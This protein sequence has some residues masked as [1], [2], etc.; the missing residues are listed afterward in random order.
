MDVAVRRHLQRDALVQVIAGHPIEVGARHLE[1]GNPRIGC[2]GNGF[3][4]AFVGLG[5]EGDVE[6]G[7]RHSGAQALEHRVA[8]E[9]GFG[10]VGALGRGARSGLRAFGGGVVGSHVS[11]RCGTAALECAP[12]LTTRARRRPLLA[13]VFTHRAAAPRV[14]GH[15]WT[16]PPNVH[17]GPSAV[18]VTSTPAFLRRSRI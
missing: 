3:G 12:A 17:C 8:A 6:R 18:S 11:G 16:S 14:A 9:D 4:E 2:S 5:A 10:L 1:D 13:A 7:R 15:Q